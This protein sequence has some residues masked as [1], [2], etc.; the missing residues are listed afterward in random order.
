VHDLGVY[1][2]DSTAT[3]RSRGSTCDTRCTRVG[4]N[5]T[6][7]LDGYNY[8][9]LRLTATSVGPG[10]FSVAVTNLFQQDAFIGGS[11]NMGEPLAL[12]QYATRADYAPYVRAGETEFFGLPYRSIYFTYSVQVK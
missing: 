12:N 11:L 3:T 7:R 2:D 4:D 6:K 8:S 5:N 1:Q 9:D 10:S